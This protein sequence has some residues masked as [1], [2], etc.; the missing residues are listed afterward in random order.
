MRLRNCSHFEVNI[1]FKKK[2]N[3][4]IKFCLSC[5]LIFFLFRC[6]VDEPTELSIHLSLKNVGRQ[7]LRP[8][9]KYPYEALDSQPLIG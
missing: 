3:A 9:S 5:F 1:F 4:K 7:P 6:V 8:I 2:Q